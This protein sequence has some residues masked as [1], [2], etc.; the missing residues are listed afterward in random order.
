[1]IPK[2]NADDFIQFIIMNIDIRLLVKILATSLI[3]STGGLIQWD[4]V[5][6]LYKIVIIYATL[7]SWLRPSRARGH[8]YAPLDI[9]KAFDMVSWSYPFFSLEKWVSPPK[10]L[11]C[12][13]SCPALCWPIWSTEASN[14]PSFPLCKAL[15]RAAHIPFF[16]RFSHWAT[17]VVDPAIIWRF[18]LI[19]TNPL[20]SLP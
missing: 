20:I 5:G 19:I 3:Q 13:W 16:F 4:Q 1:M 12:V 17:R 8:I 15:G 14:P 11:L 2:P 18:F 7:P 10:F 9:R 6:L